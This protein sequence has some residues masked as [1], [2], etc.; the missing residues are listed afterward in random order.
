MTKTPRS[1]LA[2]AGAACLFGLLA[3]APAAADDRQTCLNNCTQAGA[4][5]GKQCQAVHDRKMID[6]GKLGTNQE[7]NTC[8]REATQAL[9]DC[10]ETA[11]QKVR[12][13]QQ[14]CPPKQR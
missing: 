5:E 10:N 1:L 7:R 2:A 4:T 14:D 9:R 6:C 8:K 11:R 13:C 3:A 12:K